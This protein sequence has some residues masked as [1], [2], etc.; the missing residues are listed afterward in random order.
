[1][2]IQ[3]VK[4]TIDWLK[5]AKGAFMKVNSNRTDLWKYLEHG[6]SVKVA[7]RYICK[8]RSP[9]Y[10]QEIRPPAPILFNIIGRVTKGDRKPYRFIF[11]RSLATA[12]NNYLMLYPKGILKELIEKNPSILELVWEALNSITTAELL[13]NSRVYGGDMHKLE[14]NELGQVNAVALAKLLSKFL[15]TKQITDYF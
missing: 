8:H 6:I 14:P 11:N 15:V 4:L 7:E 10:S 12:T 5:G 9:W 2:Q 13:L 1:L 3:A